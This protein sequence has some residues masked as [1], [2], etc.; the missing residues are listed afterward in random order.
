M[1][2]S[3]H[4]EQ[5]ALFRWAAF[6]AN[7]WPELALMFAVPNGGHRHKIVAARLKAEGVKAGVPDICLPVPRGAWHGL[8]IEMKTRTGSASR[9]QKRWLGALQ[10]QGYRVAVCKGWEA[11]KELIEEYLASDADAGRCALEPPIPARSAKP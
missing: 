2:A 7:R 9:E 5:A 1:H 8:F 11:A 4:D 6:A 3:E 10:A